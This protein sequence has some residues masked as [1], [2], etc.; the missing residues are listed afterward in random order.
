MSVEKIA[1]D[2]SFDRRGLPECTFRYFAAETLVEFLVLAV[3]ATWRF[4]P[5]P[6]AYRCG[7][8]AGFDASSF[9]QGD[10]KNHRHARARWPCRDCGLPDER[11][12][13][14]AG[15]QEVTFVLSTP[16]AGIEP[17]KRAARQWE[18]GTWRENVPLRQVEHPCR[19]SR[20]RF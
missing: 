12:R 18:D 13:R 5:P 15:R 9:R 19:F 6:R 3:A 17:I 11:R 8:T 7:S 16:P 4:T 10:G 2:L 1:T 20:Q 14:S